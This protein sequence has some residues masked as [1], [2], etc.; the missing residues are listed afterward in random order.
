MHLGAAKTTARAA[1]V[2]SRADELAPEYSG[3]T[4]RW[5]VGGVEAAWLGSRGWV[6]QARRCELRLA[7]KQARC[8][9]FHPS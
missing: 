6:E 8:I 1:R 7:V 3:E 4:R 5:L 9:F 2:H